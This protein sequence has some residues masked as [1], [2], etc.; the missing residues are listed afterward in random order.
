MQ[1][2]SLS[3]FV[4]LCG[5]FSLAIALFAWRRR[6]TNGALWFSLFMLSESI[7]VIG[8]SLELASLTLENMLFWNK[9]QYLGIL[10][11]PLFFMLFVLQYTGHEK[12]LNFRKILPLFILPVI[13]M[14]LKL[15]D[16]QIHLIYKTVEVDTNASISLLAFTKGSLYIIPVI[17]N[18]IAVTIGNYYLWRKRRF[19]S[20]LYIKQ[21][22]IILVASTFLY[23]VYIFYLS[24]YRPFS[25]MQNLDFNPFVYTTWGFAIAWAIFRYHL[26]DLV[27]YA[28]EKLI[29]TLT[30]GVLVFD[31]QY[32]VV[33]ANP[34]SNKIFGWVHTPHGQYADRVFANWTISENPA[35]VIDTNL[36]SKQGTF[37]IQQEKDGK[38][39]CYDINVTILKGQQQ[40]QIDGWLM[41]MHDI[42]ARKRIE[43]ELRELSLEDELTGLNNRRGFITLANQMIQMIQR[44]NLSAVLIYIDLDVLKWVN[45]NLG[46][47]EGDQ[48]LSTIAGILLKT[49]RSSDI[50]ARLGGD[51]FVIFAI[52]SE[53]N[54]A[55]MILSRLQEQLQ[56]YNLREEKPYQLSISYGLA[57]C[58]P[59]NKCSLETLINEADRAMYEQKQSKKLNPR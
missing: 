36:L 20:S 30:E 41:V 18:L 58:N 14:I 50:V 16:D 59:E 7:Y 17:Y 53:E 13:F 21:T 39:I 26:F 22:N 5:I 29:E 28:R 31:S 51:E 43:E 45:D 4:L 34:S 33:D 40:N 8:Y 57:R 10:T 15:S 56:S 2:N 11:F 48:A 9:F 24:G 23:F 35:L 6:S 12:W 54:C 52:E 38:K 47:A 25:F 42:T 3:F 44:M 37:E 27:P 32:R 19:S 49:C 1:I 55:E 46:H